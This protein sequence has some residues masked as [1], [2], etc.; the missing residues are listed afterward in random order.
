MGEVSNIQNPIL[1]CNEEHR[2]L[3]ADQLLKIGKK[4]DSIILEPKGRDTAPALTIATL[5]IVQRDP[6]AVVVVM[7][8]DQMIP[9]MSNFSRLVEQAAVLSD[10]GSLVTFGVVP[11]RAETGY[12]YIKRGQVLSETRAYLVDKFVEKPDKET[13]KRY[14]ESGDYYWNAG[15]FVLRADVWLNEIN[16]H[17]PIILKACETSMQGKTLDSGFMRIG[18]ESFL[19][20]PAESIDYSVMENTGNAVVL[21]LP[22]SWSDVGSW[23][24]IWNLL[25]QDESGNV[26]KGDVICHETKGSLIMSESRCVATVGLEDIIIVETSD[27]VLVANKNRAQDVKAIVS[28]LKSRGRTEHLHHR[29]VHRPWGDYEGIDH[30]GRYQVKRISVKPGGKLS[31]Q[32]HHHRAEHWIVVSGTAKVV[33]GDSERL[34]SENE[35]TYIPIGVTHRLENPGTIPLELIEVQTGSYLGEDDIVRFEDIYNRVPE[36]KKAG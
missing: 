8:A 13:A 7:P 1:V 35:S 20:C 26:K 24:S 11:D 28:H 15:I 22:L 2:F 32:M 30:G 27:A 4:F 9:D 19:S 23:S 25:D 12:G 17:R 29:R 33:I 34:L 31:L 21:P 18:S 3:I 6:E 5:D 36:T 14:L 16:E 10:S